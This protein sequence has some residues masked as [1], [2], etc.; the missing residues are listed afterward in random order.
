MIILE[1]MPLLKYFAI[2]EDV[3]TKKTWDRTW[4]M[5][6]CSAHILRDM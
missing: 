4:G 3:V 1:V 2:G 5:H 6:I